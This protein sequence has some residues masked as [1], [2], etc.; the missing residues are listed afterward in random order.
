MEDGGVVGRIAD[1]IWRKLGNQRIDGDALSARVA[2]PLTTQR[3]LAAIDSQGRRHLLVALH[4]SE[5][6]FEDRRSNGIEIVTRDLLL[7]DGSRDRYLDLTCRE[8]AGFEMFS[9]LGHELALAQATEMETPADAVLRLLNKWRKFWLSQNQPALTRE[10][11][12]GLFAELWFLAFWLAPK[13]GIVSASDVW[14][15]PIAA[16]HD[17]E[18]PRF[19]VEVKATTSA[20]NRI[21]IIHG[22]DQLAV[23]DSGPLYLF[24][25]ALRDEGGGGNTLAGLVERIRILASVDE[26]TTM[27]FEARAA[28]AGYVDSASDDSQPRFRVVDERLYSVEGRFPRILRSTFENG[29]PPGVENISYAISLSGFDD[30]I[31]ANNPEDFVLS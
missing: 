16:R 19:S 21:H 24:S 14:R 27:L 6:G 5:L 29:I 30:L 31:V 22:L 23:P 1:E 3:V 12:I 13:S 20:N 17:I 4:P 15:G 2:D 10:Q 8:V 9:L 18:S 25:L 11:H 26:S 28:K 7:T